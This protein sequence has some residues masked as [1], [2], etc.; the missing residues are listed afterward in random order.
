MVGDEPSVSIMWGGWRGFGKPPAGDRVLTTKVFTDIV[1]STEL[2]ARVGDVAWDQLL[3]RHNSLV[4]DIL[5]EPRGNQIGT[6]GDGVLATFDGAAQAILATEAIR[7]AVKTLG[8][9]IRS[10]IHTGEVELVPGNLRG[11][12][13]HEAARILELAGPM[14]SWC[15]A[16]LGTWCPGAD[17]SSSTGG[18]IDSRGCPRSGRS[19][20][21]PR[22]G[23]SELDLSRSQ[24]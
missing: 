11:I 8:L 15:R 1:A 9:E 5:E 4:N 16:R 23:Q 18:C 12:A 6:T 24:G 17:S 13:V 2:A 21:S 3:D 19:S 22:M 10:A 14:K 7:D 20:P